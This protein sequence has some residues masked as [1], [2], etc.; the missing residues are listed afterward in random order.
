MIYLG[1]DCSTLAVHGAIVD[2]MEQLISLHKWGSKQ[3][4]FVERF[5]E[6][7]VG[8][9]ADF[10][11]INVI[12]EAAIEL[13]FSSKIRKQVYPLLTLSEQCGDC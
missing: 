10:S 8:F 3:K 9:S 1:L 13:L 6:I 12:D 2:E 11:K 5:P 4:T 7:L